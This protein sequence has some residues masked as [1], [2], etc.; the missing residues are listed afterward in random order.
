VDTRKLKKL[1]SRVTRDDKRSSTNNG[2]DVLIS[3]ERRQEGKITSA[4]S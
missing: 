2:V 3:R 1:R 4:S